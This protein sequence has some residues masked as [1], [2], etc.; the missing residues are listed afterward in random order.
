MLQARSL[1]T[2]NAIV[3]IALLAGVIWA[4]A[5]AVGAAPAKG[6]SLVRLD[7]ALDQIV[8]ADAKLELISDDFE[9]GDG[10]STEGP[11]WMRQPQSS[12]GGYLLFTDSRRTQITRWSP[13][14]GLSQAY[15]LKKLLG[16]LEPGRSSS[17]GIALDP[18]GRVVFCSSGKHAVVR[19]E[20]DG[21]PTILAQ[22][23]NGKRIDNPN[24]LTIKSNGAIYF[25]DNAREE[26]RQMP[27]TVYLLK[28]GKL[29][30]L[31]TDLVSPNGITMSPDGKVL[32]VNDIR[33]RKVYRYDVL[34]DDTVANG[35]LFIDMSGHKEPGS[36]DGM[37]T[38]QQGNLYDSGP[39]GVWII[40]PQGK[41][42]GTIVT[43]DR[44]TNLGFGGT[45][46]KTLFLTA[47]ASLFRIRLKAAGELRP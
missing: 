32:Y 42:L 5:F 18:Q 43:P 1:R 11:V 24:D 47:H 19:I 20:A 34:P 30:A 31:I 28:D 39:G 9:H 21:K 29:T 7:P 25:T 38:D 36:N 26:T 44:I 16:D 23:Y 17:S 35:R 27:P 37:K 10:P 4:G 2:Q 13:S 3:N 6:Q 12:D 33:P 22:T 8:A 15:D 41:H 40:S 14:A 45:D 46:G